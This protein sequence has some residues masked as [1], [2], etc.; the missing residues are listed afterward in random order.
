MPLPPYHIYAV[1]F[2][3]SHLFLIEHQI[4]N[5][6]VPLILCVVNSST[7]CFLFSSLRHPQLLVYPPLIFELSTIVSF[8]QEHLH[9]QYVFLEFALYTL[10]TTV[11]RLNIFP[12]KSSK[13]YGVFP[14]L[15]AISQSPLY[16][17]TILRIL[18]QF[19]NFTSIR[20]Y[21]RIHLKRR[22]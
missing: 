20:I 8:P 3:F 2:S 18:Y 9:F 15:K 22:F 10:S 11:R 14:F 16:V 7:W 5:N 6:L 17:Y 21:G 13:L 19:Y 4:L 1:S 12:V